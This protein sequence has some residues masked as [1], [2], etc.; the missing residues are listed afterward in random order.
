MGGGY[1]AGSMYADSNV[2]LLY[3][4]VLWR[5]VVST[6]CLNDSFVYKF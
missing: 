1:S 5:F 6:I 2:G 4:V 3:S